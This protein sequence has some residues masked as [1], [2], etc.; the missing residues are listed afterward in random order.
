MELTRATGPKKEEG[1]V[2][3][4]VARG[5]GKHGGGREGLGQGRKAENTAQ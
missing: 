5:K 4:F 2:N 3:R 1:G